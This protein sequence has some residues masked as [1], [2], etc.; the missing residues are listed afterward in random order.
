MDDT[1]GASMNHGMNGSAMP[2]L[3][4]LL[5]LGYLRPETI[6]DFLEP[7]VRL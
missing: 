7:R 4:G 6:W 1:R 5:A 2:H 3:Q